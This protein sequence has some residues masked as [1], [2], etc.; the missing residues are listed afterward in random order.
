MNRINQKLQQLK[1]NNKKGLILFFVSGFPDITT[2]YELVLESEK[3]GADIIELGLPYS[4]PI[5]DGKVI[6]SASYHALLGGTNIFNTLDLVEK[7]R[8]YSQVPLIIMT[9]YNPI[10]KYGV[11]KFLSDAKN[12]GV[13][14]I[15]ITDILPES[16]GEIRSIS[17]KLN[18]SIIYLL[19]PTSTDERIIY[20]DKYTTSFIYCI[21][22]TGT[23]GEQ[24]NIDSSLYNFVK[25]VRKYSK[26][27]IAVGFG[28]STFNQA[29][30]ISKI[31]DAIV[32]G[33]AIVNIILQEKNKEM[34]ILKVKKFVEEIRKI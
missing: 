34:S 21:S 24:K 29:K 8:K 23:T 33:S 5:A 27:P 16:A 32:V 19:A 2:T 20:V 17:E 12:K 1:N 26:K 22:R 11:K 18:I 31:S 28:I 6:Q 10:Y 25:R 7:I 15:I 3:S 9:Y 14:G 13:D 4:D 30:K